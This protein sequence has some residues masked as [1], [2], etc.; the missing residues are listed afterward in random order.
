MDAYTPSRMIDPKS[1]ERKLH[2]IKQDGR[3]IPFTTGRDQK[4]RDNSHQEWY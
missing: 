4:W 3:T 2:V 1:E